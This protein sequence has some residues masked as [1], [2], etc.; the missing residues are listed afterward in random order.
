MV[1][2]GGVGSVWLQMAKLLRLPLSLVLLREKALSSLKSY[3]GMKHRLQNR[4]FYQK[5]HRIGYCGG[6]VGGET[7]QKSFSS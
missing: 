2:A 6:L 1:A 3:E 4:I 7:Q 5:Q